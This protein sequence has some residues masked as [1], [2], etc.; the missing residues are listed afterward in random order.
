MTCVDFARWLDDGCPES[1]AI[2]ARAHAASCARCAVALSAAEE[3]DALLTGTPP[4][5]PPGFTDAIMARIGRASHARAQASAPIPSPIAWWVRALGDPASALAAVVAGLLLWQGE[6]LKNW[7]LGAALQLGQAAVSLKLPAL[8]AP[9]A[10]P[11]VTLGLSLALVP[12]AAWLAWVLY[13]WTEG[14]VGVRGSG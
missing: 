7:A 12:A 3:L 4:A 10:R 2:A 5:A 8:G 13:R 14:L 6:A 9:Y 11:E 1:D